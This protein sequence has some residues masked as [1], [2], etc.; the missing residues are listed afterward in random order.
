MRRSGG[1]SAAHRRMHEIKR[2]LIV[3]PARRILH[4]HQIGLEHQEFFQRDESAIARRRAGRR[5]QP[6]LLQQ[7]CGER[8]GP[9]RYS[10]RARPRV[11][12]RTAGCAAP[13][14]APAPHR[15]R[16]QLFA[17]F[18]MAEE[19]RQCEICARAAARS[20][21]NS[22]STTRKPCEASMRRVTERSFGPTNTRSG[23][24]AMVDSAC[25]SSLRIAL[26]SSADHRQAGIGGIGREPGDL[27]RI[28]Q[29]HHQLVGAEIERDDA[30]RA[31]R[32]L[33]GRRSRTAASSS[34]TT[35][36]RCTRSASFC[37]HAGIVAPDT[38]TA[39]RLD[40]KPDMYE[41]TM[42]IVRR[43]IGVSA[44]FV[45][46][47][48]GD[49]GRSLMV[50]PAGLSPRAA[51]AG[52][53][54]RRRPGRHH[55]ARHPPAAHIAGGA[56]RRNARTV[57]RRLAGTAAQSAGRARS[58][59]RAAG[60]RR[61]VIRR[62]RVRLCVG[63]VARGAVRRH[64]RR[65]RVH[66]RPGRDRRTAR[67]PDRHPAGRTCACELRRRHDRAHPQS[68]AQS[69]HRAGSRVLAARLAGRPLRRSPADRGAVHGR[70]LD[71]AACRMRAPFARS[72]SAKMPP[73]RSASTSCARAC[74]S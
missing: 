41:S 23:C 21:T 38:C 27:L 56:D 7:G 33:G 49:C 34:A 68:R 2:A 64:C 17:A 69:V 26:A 57:R 6:G 71:R 40:R 66:R 42:T 28:G 5:L 47:A 60:G 74:W 10:R 70:E 52:S 16:H 15:D 25:Q 18:G 19:S 20:V 8:R 13:P 67:E 44:A 43:N 55:R 50:G 12:S 62:D 3:R 72:R 39:I 61:G 30:L 48:G 11:R 58:V 59:R 4:E 1:Y 73:P 53:V 54:L 46:A 63:D 65:A 35:N 37:A 45:A 51:F 31:R 24:S 14:G 9:L 36:T 29:R 22:T 32:A